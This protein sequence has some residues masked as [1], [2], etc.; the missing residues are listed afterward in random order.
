MYILKLGLNSYLY[1]TIK[2]KPDKTIFLEKWD[3]NLL[4]VLGDT[5]QEE[6]IKWVNS[7]VRSS[8]MYKLLDTSLDAKEVKRKLELWD[9][10]EFGIAAN[11]LQITGDWLA[12][13]GNY[14]GAFE[15][16]A[17][18]W[19]ASG[20]TQSAASMANMLLIDKTIDKNGRILPIISKIEFDSND[21]MT[22]D[23]MENV[24]AFHIITAKAIQQRE[25]LDHMTE[26]RE[27]DHWEKALEWEKRLFEIDSSSIG[28]TS[29]IYENMGNFYMSSSNSND[30]IEEYIRAA[31]SYLHL[32]GTDEALSFLERL[33]GKYLTDFSDTDK[34]R[35][36]ITEQRILMKDLLDSSSELI[37]NKLIVENAIPVREVWSMNRTLNEHDLIYNKYRLV[38]H[39]MPSTFQAENKKPF[40]F[41]SIEIGDF[42]T[43]YESVIIDSNNVLQASKEYFR[44]STGINTEVIANLE[45]LRDRIQN[46]ER[47]DIDY[48][49]FNIP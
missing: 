40:W 27:L 11:F 41:Q 12:K 42:S 31:E 1:Y 36:A 6:K 21:I 48:L 32:T 17:S 43:Y 33:N 46:A 35:L 8:R 15:R 29:L 25:E 2:A 13:E 22:I 26:K 34:K 39:E 37:H 45:N 24:S 19:V 38:S 5:E 7:A 47:W 44:G 4:P 14:E 9:E 30:A 3:N 49:D 10:E 28:A 18:S 20:N 16:Y 23:D